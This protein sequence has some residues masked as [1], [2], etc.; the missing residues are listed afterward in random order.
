MPAVGPP[1]HTTPDEHPLGNARPTP[2]HHVGVERASRQTPYLRRRRPTRLRA[3]PASVTGQSHVSLERHHGYFVR[4]Y[5]M[6]HRSDDTPSAHRSCPTFVLIHGI[7]VSARYFIPLAN[8]LL[9]DGDVLMMD[10]PGF[11][12]LP[13]PA[14]TMSVSAFAAVIHSVI[15]SRGIANPVIFGHSMGA[16]FSVELAA[17]DPRLA[18]RIML[19]GP[20]V[21]VAAPTLI[22]T[23]VRFMRTSIWESPRLTLI[24]ARAYA[25][26]GLGWFMRI[27]QSMMD[28]PIVDRLRLTQARITFGRGE[29]DY[30]AH[31]GWLT[32]LSRNTDYPTT[33]TQFPHAAHSV[34]YAHSGLIAQHLV[35]LA[36]HPTPDRDPCAT[37]TKDD[38]AHATRIAIA[39]EDA[40]AHSWWLGG[41]SPLVRRTATALRTVADRCVGVLQTGVDAAI[42]ATT[43]LPDYGLFLV[44]LA[45]HRPHRAHQTSA[46]PDDAPTV[47]LLHGIAETHRTMYPLRDALRDAGYRVIYPNN[48]GLMNRP[49]GDLIDTFEQWVAT[50]QLDRFVI[51]GHSKG[52]LLAK[53]FLVRHPECVIGVVTLGTPWWGSSMVRWLTKTSPMRELGPDADII[54]DLAKHRTYNHRIVSLG[55]TDDEQIPEGTYLPGA[56][57]D[58][59]PVV[60]HQNLL[61]APAAL[62]ATRRHVTNLCSCLP[63][64]AEVT[65]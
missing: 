61:V 1:G 8:T 2:P 22:Q 34:I 36:T 5:H 19:V 62:N 12:N 59:L 25:A 13:Q 53:M 16:Q 3:W 52:G 56:V 32:Y 11:S 37:L 18:N 21:D 28:Y 10:L 29:H 17:R 20:P 41:G 39:D 40:T 6:F 7:G 33:I 51:V 43:A 63:T 57:N 14:T 9:H 60:G 48:L 65:T 54:A 45:R 46:T 49:L 38:L 47:V 26:C 64:T 31:P 30:V 42:W 23:A 4:V 50:Q 35:E 15:T 24:A 58:T 55:A 44:R 27:L